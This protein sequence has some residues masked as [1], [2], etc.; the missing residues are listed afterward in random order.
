[1][2]TIQIGL[3]V[4]KAIEAARLALD[5]PEDAILMRLLKL[6]AQH[7]ARS[8]PATPTAKAWRKN[9]VELPDGTLLE[10]DYAGQHIIGVVRDGLWLVQGRAFPSPSKALIESV[11]TRDGR[12]TSLNGWS[13]WR[14]K[15]PG[16]RGFS[17]LSALRPQGAAGHG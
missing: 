9:G 12:R 5:E 14:V 16:D 17:R 4:H 2:R 8:A 3:E 1:M 6:E 13:H 7:A 15:R 11:T 10:A